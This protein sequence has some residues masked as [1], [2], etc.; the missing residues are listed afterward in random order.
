M[1]T[2]LTMGLSRAIGATSAKRLVRRRSDLVLLAR[3]TGK[4]QTLAAAF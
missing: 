3:A 4:P 2:A 1:P